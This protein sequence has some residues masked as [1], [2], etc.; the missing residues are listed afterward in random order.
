MKEPG[1]TKKQFLQEIRDLRRR[2]IELE[3][4]KIQHERTEKALRESEERLRQVM[5]LVPH[6]IFARDTTGKIILS[7]KAFAQIFDKTVDKITGCLFNDLYPW[8]EEIKKQ[9]EI[10]REI[11][12]NG[13]PLYIP[14]QTIRYPD[15]TVHILQTTKIPFTIADTGEPAVLVVSEDKTE[16]K[17]AEEALR[18]SEARYRDLIENTNDVIFILDTSG[19]ITYI[20]MVVESIYGYSPAELIGH[21]FT[22]YVYPEELPRVS[23]IFRKYLLGDTQIEE[24]RIVDRWGQ[25]RY[26]RASA[27]QLN[28]GGKVVGLRGVMIDITERKNAVKKLHDNNR[29]HSLFEI[30]QNP[31][32]ISTRDG[33][34]ID[35]NRA[36]LDLFGYSHDEIINSNITQH[37]VNPKDRAKIFTLL[38]RDGFVKDFSVK[39]FKKDGSVLN[40]HITTNV[41]YT[42]GGT[43]LG[44]LTFVHEATEPAAALV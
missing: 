8:K 15:G 11:I 36:C 24:F 10:D 19:K 14:Y 2:V 37:Y 34:I 4:I 40:C 23:K 27:L 32:A 3:N 17:K 43:V 21:Y 12:R 18:N 13:K 33:K 44:Y 41:L 5:D 26:V 38:E 6:N 16:Q 31:F 28:K 35:V 29:Y 39:F 20:S 1:K 30:S 25:T 7:N 42:N 22:D 9:Q